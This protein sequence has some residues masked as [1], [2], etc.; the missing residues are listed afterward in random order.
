MPFNKDFAWGT[1]TAAYQIEGTRLAEGRKPCVWDMFCSKPGATYLGHDGSSG[2]EH[3]AHMKEDVALMKQLGINA[4]RFSISWPWV[5]PD[6]TGKVNEAALDFYDRLVDEL[7]DAGIAPWVTLFHWD[8]PLELYRRG[9]WLNRDIAD[10]FS[11]YAAVCT[12]RLSDRVA[13]WLT[14][15]EPQCFILAGLQSGGHAPGDRLQTGLVASAAHNALLAHG[16]AVQAIRGHAQKPVKVG[17][18]PIGTACYPYTDSAEDV[19]AARQWFLNPQGASM[20]PTLF[21]A[22]PVFGK[23]YPEAI[24][25]ALGADAPKPQQ[26]DMEII[27]QPLDVC[28][29][30]TY[31]GCCIKAGK[32]G[33]PEFVPEPVGN[34]LTAMKW[35]ITPEALYYTPKWLYE[36]YGKPVVVTENGM[37]NNDVVHLDGKVHDSQRIDYLHRYLRELKRAA[38]DGVDVAGYFLWSLMDNFEWA[39]GFKQRFGI[40]HVDYTTKQRIPKDSYW[41]YKECIAANGA[42]L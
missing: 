32:D 7:V 33:T 4:Y 21:W 24:M 28:A 25:Q 23:G 35:P 12:Y 34:P 16:K 17:M 31:H 29:F 40:I 20:D 15:N 10:W 1:A 11:Y 2:P 36:R 38:D 41:W 9:G 30:N 8:L 37:S 22:D 5:M 27:A 42:N 6:G 39:E 13:N 3:I 19:E 18:V 14:L 26:G